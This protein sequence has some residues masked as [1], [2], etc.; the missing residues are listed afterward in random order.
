MAIYLIWLVATYMRPSEPLTVRRGDL[1]GPVPGVSSE[2]HVSLFP[3]ER[4]DRSKTYA[5]N[6]SVC[7]TIFWAPWFPQLV[8]AL[9]KG[10]GGEK[11]FSFSYP[12][13]LAIFESCRKKLGLGAIVPYEARHSGPAIDM[14]RGHRNRQQIRERGRWKSEKS[15]IR[16]EQ[17]A[18]LGQSYQRLPA[19][20]QTLLNRCERHLGDVLLG[21]MPADAQ[22][23][24]GR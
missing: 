22:C 18:R 10:R 24:G 2:W 1:V 17:R 14:A 8:A 6:D 4:P 12:S 13:F 3:E 20:I 7:L 16:Y 9:A 23:L 5:S 11:L 19:H 15:V 21:R